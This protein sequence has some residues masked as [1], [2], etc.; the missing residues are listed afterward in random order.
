[1][2]KKTSLKNK[3]EKIKSLLDSLKDDDI[4][5]FFSYIS[6]GGTLDDVYSESSMNLEDDLISKALKLVIDDR[7]FG[8]EMDE[9]FIEEAESITK[10]NMYNIFNNDNKPEA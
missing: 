7:L 10:L 6:I 1:M 2:K 5:F 4:R 3:L 8:N 9:G